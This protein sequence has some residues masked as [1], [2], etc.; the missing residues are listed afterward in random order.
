MRGSQD[1]DKDHA[2]G[3][4]DFRVTAESEAPSD[5]VTTWEEDTWSS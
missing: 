4:N 3:R 5:G 1:D 2:Q